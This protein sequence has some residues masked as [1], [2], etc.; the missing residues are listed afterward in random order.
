MAEVV[1]VVHALDTI[2][3]LGGG[4]A[5]AV[6]GLCLALVAKGAD[7]RVVAGRD[8]RSEEDLPR[9]AG[10]PVT[11]VEPRGKIDALTGASFAAAVRA[12]A[13]ELL[14]IHGVWGP[15]SRASVRL[16]AEA[17]V[18]LSPHG[19]FDAWAMRRSRIKKRLS[20]WVWERH[21]LRHARLFHALC[22]P[23]VD[24]IRAIHAR[25][26]IVT[27]PNGVT[28]PKLDSA[29]DVD[30]TRA[31]LLFL[32][33]LH[34]KKG[35]GELIAGW[36]LLPPTLRAS[37]RLVIAGWDE[38]GLLQD[39]AAQAETLGVAGEMHFPGPVLGAAKDALFRSAAAFILPSYSEGLPLSV[40]E[41]WSYALP[42]FITEACNLPIGFE[43]NAAFRVT[44]A[45]GEIA[46]ALAARLSDPAALAAAGYAGRKLAERDYSWESV[47]EAMLTAYAELRFTKS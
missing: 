40:L 5:E 46:A 9:W 7:V 36:A 2:S 19:M 13:P 45:P 4:V 28:L 16:L 25:A 34:P 26:A 14:H 24:S 41:A 47:A 30:A 42:V 22:V 10:V 1:R 38:L 39:L 6:R 44:T 33:R 21:L 31:T 11:L 15:A 12:A 17:I 18:V 8:V 43:R 29:P 32:G 3:M 27:I 37:W 20:A 23:E 35:V